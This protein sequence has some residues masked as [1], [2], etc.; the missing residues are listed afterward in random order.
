[1]SSILSILIASLISGIGVKI[2]DYY[3]H[4]ALEKNKAQEVTVNTDKIAIDILAK[5][6]ETLNEQVVEPLREENKQ[7]AN[8]QKNILNE[9]KKLR[10]AIERIPGCAH[11]ATCPVSMELQNSN[12]AADTGAGTNNH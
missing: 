7:S 9:L 10:K 1:M 5:A 12:A 6:M 11:A 3:Q 4:R 2:F 8:N